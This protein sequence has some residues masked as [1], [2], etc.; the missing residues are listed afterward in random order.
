MLV[1]F[2]AF[3]TVVINMVFE[4]LGVTFDNGDLYENPLEKKQI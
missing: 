3:L 1:C 2:T 4:F